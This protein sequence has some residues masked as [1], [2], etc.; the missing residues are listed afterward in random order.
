MQQEV[1]TTRSNEMG[2]VDGEGNPM[3][4]PLRQF[5][6]LWHGASTTVWVAKSSLLDGK[7]GLSLK[8]KNIAPLKRN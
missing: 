8:N 6:N 3:L 4:D 2:I 7:G 1:R 5:R